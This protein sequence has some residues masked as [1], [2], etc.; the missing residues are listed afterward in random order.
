MNRKTCN[1][2]RGS[3]F[4]EFALLLPLL[5]M[6]MVGAID[7][8][9]VFSAAMTTAD[10]TRAGVQYGVHSNVYSVNSVAIKQAAQRDAVNL[11]TPMT[12][13]NS[14]YCKCLNSAATAKL[15]CATVTCSEGAPQVYVEVLASNTFSTMFRFPGVPHTLEIQQS[16]RYRSQ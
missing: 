7:F 11:L 5:G 12:V 16:T 4:I 1:S 14:T 2:R 10:A 8:A 9:R 13:T 15:N 6:I 3:S